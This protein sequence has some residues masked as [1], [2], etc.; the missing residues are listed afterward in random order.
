MKTTLLAL[1]SAV[2]VL[3]PT[4]TASDITS[5]VSIRSPKDAQAVFPGSLD[6]EVRFIS[7]PD[8][9]VLIRSLKL[10]LDG[11][12]VSTY[13][14]ESN[15]RDGSHTFTLHEA[16]LSLGEHS[17]QAFAEQAGLL[18]AD[19][20]RDGNVNVLD[21]IF[22]RNRLQT[23]D[24]D[25]SAAADATGDGRVNILDLIK[26]RNDLGK[27]PNAVP[28][29]SSSVV[30][31]IHTLIKHPTATPEGIFTRQPTLVTVT[32]EISP[33]LSRP[34]VVLYRI[35][36]SR[37]ETLGSLH[38]DGIRGDAVAGDNVFSIEKTFSEPE[39]TQIE[40]QVSV[41]DTLH[42]LHHFSDVFRVIVVPPDLELDL[43]KSLRLMTCNTQLLTSNL[44]MMLMQELGLSSEIDIEDVYGLDNEERAELIAEAILNMSPRPDIIAFQEVFDEDGRYGLEQKLKG[45]YPNYVY[46]LDACD[47]DPEDSGLMLFSRFPF[48][49]LPDDTY[50]ACSVE[51]YIK[52]YGQVEDWDDDVAFIEFDD[53]SSPDSWAN[54]G[55]GLVRIQISPPPYGRYAT[56][57][58]AH[59]QASYGGDDQPD[60]RERIRNRRDQLDDIREIIQGSLTEAH[61]EYEPV[62]VMGDLNINGNRHSM[63]GYWGYDSK[64]DWDYW[65]STDDDW[66]LRTYEWDYHFNRHVHTSFFSTYL[67]DSWMYD[68]ADTDPGQTTGGD[69]PLYLDYIPDQGERLDYI[70][71]SNNSVIASAPDIQPGGGFAGTRMYTIQHIRR[72]WEPALGTTHAFSD[73]LGLMAD[74]NLYSPYCNPLTACV[75]IPN[76]DAQVQ[77]TIMHKGSMQWYLVGHEGGSYSILTTGDVTFDV[78]EAWDLSRP[79]QVTGEMTDWGMQYSIPKAPFYVRVFAKDPYWTGNY[80][81]HFHHHRGASKDDAILLD[82]LATY[83]QT[84]SYGYGYFYQMPTMYQINPEDIVW[85][86]I[87]P[88]KGDTGSLSAMKG[89]LDFFD[90]SPDFYDDN[91]TLDLVTDDETVVAASKQITP[92]PY[93]EVPYQVPQYDMWREQ[94]QA[95]YLSKEK[96]YLRVHSV[97]PSMKGYTFVIHWQTNVT[98]FVPKWLKCYEQDD[99]FGDDDIFCW[100]K[101]DG[102][103]VQD[104]KYLGEF[105]DGGEDPGEYGTKMPAGGILGYKYVDRIDMTL[106]DAEGYPSA[107]DWTTLGTET[108]GALPMNE[109]ERG[110]TKLWQK[111]DPDDD[112]DWDYRLTGKLYHQLKK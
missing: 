108:I 10:H 11:R 62:F 103:L 78:Y 69:Y 24:P 9:D 100:I 56:V 111:G 30:T 79:I 83:Q 5:R 43:G 27:Q 33:G 84:S 89:I 17:L 61:L 104:E 44:G 90:L 80:T 74:V 86:K 48:T 32:A 13:Q 28:E 93:S 75:A 19:V 91:F 46:K 51:A 110:V 68:T 72:V 54:K 73:H 59:T 60:S 1:L 2:A 22:V 26:V 97:Y 99:N 12:E 34:Q 66:L 112:P 40:L 3:L 16:G 41:D 42:Q 29:V 106:R 76:P 102:S 67:T 109:K 70:L 20:N 101:V 23:S 14:N 49:E 31:F 88:E 71:H 38:D 96:Y 64:D 50:E 47:L 85:F 107:T 52:P 8:S 94:L 15:A 87:R 77:G 105:D 57:A 82:P 39:I 53:H 92:F 45:T 58:F 65:K 63:D 95:E 4:A 98:H 6:V 7:D 18:S 21:L 55:V 81:V 35:R 36:G 25:A 37:P